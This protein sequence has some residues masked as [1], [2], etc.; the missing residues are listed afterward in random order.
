[1]VVFKQVNCVFPNY[2]G[3]NDNL[4]RQSEFFNEIHQLMSN[5]GTLEEGTTSCSCYPTS[6]VGES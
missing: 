3:M 4:G 1:M 6:H 2:F 5:D